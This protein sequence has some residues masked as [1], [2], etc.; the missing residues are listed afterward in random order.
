MEKEIILDNKTETVQ[1]PN[2]HIDDDVN[3]CMDKFYEEM[4]ACPEWLCKFDDHKKL[5]S[6]LTVRC[7]EKWLSKFI[8]ENK[9]EKKE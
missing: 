2:T 6:I 5:Y 7:V 9:Q 3:K 1:R 4:F 8:L